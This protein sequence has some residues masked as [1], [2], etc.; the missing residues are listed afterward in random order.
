MRLEEISNQLTAAAEAGEFERVPALVSQYRRRFDELWSA[1]REPSLPEQALL[2]C[3]GA[4]ARLIEARAAKAAE[5][6]RVKLASP[7]R[8][9]NTASAE[10]RM[11]L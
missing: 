4:I 2:L 10:W 7:Y 6:R 11:T 9:R 5:L 3:R 8:R 1:R